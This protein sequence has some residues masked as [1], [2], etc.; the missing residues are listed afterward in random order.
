MGAWGRGGVES[1]RDVGLGR[2]VEPGRDVGPVR[3]SRPSTDVSGPTR[4]VLRGPWPPAAP[5]SSSRPFVPA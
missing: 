1:G 3:A 5:G 2:D 4:T